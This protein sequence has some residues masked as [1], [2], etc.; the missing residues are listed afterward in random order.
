[1]AK[2]TSADIKNGGISV[3]IEHLFPI[4]KKWLYTDKEIF[5]REIV[6]NSCDAITK[7][8]KLI[9]LGEA[10]DVE[11]KDGYRIDVILDPTHKTISVKDNGIGMTADEIEK[12]LCQIALSGA[13][14]FMQKYESDDSKENNGII[15]HFGLG[16]Y[17]S[18]MVSKTVD[19]I[20]KS[21]SD[22]KITKWTCDDGGDFSIED[23]YKGDEI[24]DHG[25][26]VIMHIN[27][28]GKE[29]LDP[30]TL[31]NSLMKYCDFMPYDIYFHNTDE[32]KEEVQE[33]NTSE[34][35][36]DK[37]PK[38][39]EP[40]NDTHPLWQKAPNECTDDEYDQFYIKV[41][42]DYRKPLFHIHLNADYPLNF[43]GILFFPKITNEY[44]SLEGQVKLYYNQVFVADNIKE[45]IPEYLLM[46]RGVLDCPELPLNVS[47]SDLQTNSYVNKVSNYITKKVA[48]TLN[49]MF[50]K[51]RPNYEI[52]RASC[53]E[54]V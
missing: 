20:S 25:T 35:S 34:E 41:F 9:S 11:V 38:A 10:K 16:F 18:F 53:R 17:S 1:M 14:D 40:I 5:I 47:R 42:K 4:I 21:Y 28:E 46:L 19:V 29:Y 33:D 22:S 50:K 3:Q 32:K 44:Q 36:K 8:K 6:S 2:K 26:V 30:Y 15:G 52:G 31:K 24:K 7:L 27:S 23:D 49:S 13:L 39:E 51:D 48:D 43:K 45:I 12:Y 37:K 54:R